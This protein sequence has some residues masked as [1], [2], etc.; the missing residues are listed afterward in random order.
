MCSIRWL[1]IVM[2][3]ALSFIGRCMQSA[4]IK[5]GMPLS[6]TSKVLGLGSPS[7]R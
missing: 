3:K 4:F 6:F 2:S 7:V 5:L 1:L